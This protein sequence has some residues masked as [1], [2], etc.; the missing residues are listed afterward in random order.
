MTLPYQRELDFTIA[1]LERMRVPVHLLHKGDPL[2]Q[3]DSGFRASIGMHADYDIALRTAL[4]WPQQRTIYKVLD[5]FMCNYIH[6]PL[7]ATPEPTAMII[8]P[9]LTIDPTQAMLLEQTERLGLSLEHVQHQQDFYASLPVFHDP[10]P[11]ITVVT[12]LGEKI[13][14]SASAFDVVDMNYEQSSI[15]PDAHAADA[16]IEQENILQQMQQMEERYAYENE[17]M[18]IVSKG[19]TNRAE[20]MMSSVSQL[21]YQPRVPDPLRNHKNYCI[22]CNTL[23]RKAAQQGGVHPFHLDKMSSH[24][25][26]QIENAPNLETASHLISD[27]IRGY[28][29]LVRVKAHAQHSALIDRTLTYIDSNLSGDL[30]L[31]T[32]SSLLQITPSYLSNLFHRET[33]QT[34]ACHINH[35]RLNAA[36]HLL[37]NTRLQVQTV[38]QL[39]GFAD[40]NYFSKRFKQQYG[41]TPAQYRLQQS[42]LL[43]EV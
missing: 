12:C 34:I 35:K 9:Y 18:E 22:I 3:V 7:P 4:Q 11:V 10:T 21:N 28:C 38:A 33:G 5:Q 19:L 25:A 43:H 16:P 23:L 41:V 2:H 40:P 17:L 32:L 31:H 26:R 27:M 20:I 42:A 39:S 13:W 14:G 24:Y 15:L 6:F 36:C 30:S 8:G 37:G 29:R 1:I